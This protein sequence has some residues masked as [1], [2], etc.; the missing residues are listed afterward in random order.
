M[1]QHSDSLTVLKGI[2][3]LVT[4]IFHFQQCMIHGLVIVRKSRKVCVFR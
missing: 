1:S 4:E 2:Y 3:F